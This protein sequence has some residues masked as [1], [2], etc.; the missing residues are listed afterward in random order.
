[1]SSYSP[2]RVIVFDPVS[3]FFTSS[4]KC[5]LI[6]LKDIEFHQL[7][8]MPIQTNDLFLVVLG[9]EFRA[10]CLLSTA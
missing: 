5:D 7:E 9:F 2:L 10:F 6:A 3:N 4:S 1:V 8:E